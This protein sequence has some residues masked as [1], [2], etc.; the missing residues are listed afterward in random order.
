MNNRAK[1][2]FER[3]SLISSNPQLMS[4]HIEKSKFCR[5]SPCKNDK[6]NFAHNMQEFKPPHCLYEE[7]CPNKNCQMFHPSENVNEYMKRVNIIPPVQKTLERTKFCRHNPCTNEKCTFAHTIEEYNPPPCVYKNFCK[8][9]KCT[10]FHIGRET[11]EEYMKKYNITPTPPKSPEKE[12]K[13]ICTKMCSNMSCTIPCT[14]KDCGFAHSI[15]ELVPINCVSTNCKNSECIY[16]HNGQDIVDYAKKMG[17]VLQDFM[18]RDVSSNKKD[19][20]QLQIEAYEQLKKDLYDHEMNLIQ[21]GI[22]CISLQDHCDYY[23]H[24]YCDYDSYSDEFSDSGS[25]TDTED[26]EIEVIINK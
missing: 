18:F 16:Y 7:F 9:V 25:D 21:Q 20:M 19:F 6:C 23:E 14:K 10:L 1:A 26:D 8:N 24:D 5:Y 22:C 12:K 15:K 13:T 3:A 2:V 4:K 17:T 11:L